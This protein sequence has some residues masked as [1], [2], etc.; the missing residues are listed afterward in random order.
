MA[1]ALCRRPPSEHWCSWLA[2]SRS[3]GSDGRTALRGAGWRPRDAEAPWAAVI[4][5]AFS[6]QPDRRE[7]TEAGE[8]ENVNQEK[9]PGRIDAPPRPLCARAKA[10]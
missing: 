5:T 1:G 10:D 8:K 6:C 7:R 2:A 4:L 9:G 3:P